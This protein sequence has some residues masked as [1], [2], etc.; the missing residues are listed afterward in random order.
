MASENRREF[1]RYAAKILHEWNGHPEIFS[2]PHK[3][4]KF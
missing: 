3:K 4:E 1:I 2:L